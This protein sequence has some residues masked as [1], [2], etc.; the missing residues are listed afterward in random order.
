MSA[1]AASRCWSPRACNRRLE[2]GRRRRP[3]R[4]TWQPAGLA[5]CP[6]CCRRYLSS[7]SMPLA[8]LSRS[9]WSDRGSMRSGAQRAALAPSACGGVHGSFEPTFGSRGLRSAS[10]NAWLSAALRRIVWVSSMTRTAASCTLAITKSVSVRPCSSAARWN[11]AF[12]S[13]E[14]RALVARL[15]PWL[16]LFLTC[17]AYLELRPEPG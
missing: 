6:A 8:K 11:R 16:W 2:R 14:T 7:G 12:W 10:A 4:S 13:R 1:S 15:A 5:S 17:R 9:C 3:A